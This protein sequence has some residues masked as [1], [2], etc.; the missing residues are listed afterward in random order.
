MKRVLA[1]VL[2]S[3]GAL[4]ACSSGGKP[5]PTPLATK[6][7]GAEGG[8]LQATGGGA[9]V[10]I[11]AGAL[12][13]PVKVTLEPAPTAPDGVVGAAWQLGPEGT[14]FAAPVKLELDVDMGAMP[15]GVDPSWLTVARLE[16]GAWNPLV[17]SFVPSGS[18]K[19]V[20]LT[21]H[22]SVYAVVYKRCVHDAECAAPAQC[23]NQQTC[24]VPCRDAT[25][26]PAPMACLGGRCALQQCNGDA[27]CP[28]PN[29]C[30][31]F[32]EGVGFCMDPCADATT[33]GGDQS[34]AAPPQGGASVCQFDAC[35]TC[36]AG[37]VCSGDVCWP[38]TA[39]CKCG[40]P[41]CLC[42]AP[43][44]DAGAAVD[45]SPA[46]GAAD[47]GGASDGGPMGTPSC[48][49]PTPPKPLL[50]NPG[51]EGGTFEALV[52]RR[53][54]SAPVVDTVLAASTGGGLWRSV[55]SGAT[56]ARVTGV[57][58]RS[59]GA[60]A[61]DGTTFYAGAGDQNEPGAVYASNDGATWSKV[62]LDGDAVNALVAHKGTLWA[63]TDQGLF[64]SSDQGKTFASRNGLPA[65][66]RILS[67]EA[68]DEFVWAGT[69]AAGAFR[70]PA[71]AGDF[72]PLSTGLPTGAYVR[73]L[74]AVKLNGVTTSILAGID[75]GGPMGRGEVFEQTDGA[76][77]VAAS[78][79]FWDD[80]MAYKRVDEFLQ[81]GDTVYAGCD[82]GAG[83][84]ARPAA[85]GSTWSDMTGAV[86]N[87]NILALAAS[88]DGARLF[89]GNFGEG[90]LTGPAGGTSWSRTNGGLLA[91]RVLALAAGKSG[92]ADALFAGT[93]GD[94]VYRSLDGGNNWARSSNGLP[95][96]FV[97]SLDA[98][99]QDVFAGNY[100]AGL[101]AS[102]DGA[103]TWRLANGSGTSALGN[104]LV[105]ALAHDA[106]GVEY[107]GTQGGGV[108]ESIGTDQWAPVNVGLTDLAVDSLLLAPDGKLYAGTSSGSVWVFAGASWT[109][110][111][112]GLPAQAQIMDLAWTPSGALCAA[113]GPL[114]CMASPSPGGAWLNLGGGRAG[115]RALT[116]ADGLVYMGGYGDV[117]E[118]LD[119]AGKCW[120]PE[121]PQSTPVLRM[122]TTPTSVVIGT[123]NG[124]LVQAR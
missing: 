32:S 39:G 73:A 57:S 28:A 20:A 5:T 118:R 71:A 67:V 47:D 6:V 77:W 17:A 21:R 84:L 113:F 9:T 4:G 100:G 82:W 44:H 10:T 89:L 55:D 24:V 65:G 50:Q 54:S 121:L 75:N 64:A 45:A 8:T 19:A 33:C 94:S 78:Q 122:L 98:V 31:G 107:V 60:L 79:G 109:E 111:G 86:E 81:L 88:S 72:T 2:A 95:A 29:R 62:G 66:A 18:M 1:L 41:G 48:D 27:D 26:C 40:T 119:L 102:N 11:P 43:A 14:I 35:G 56:W 99:G 70:A 104:L 96:G 124:L 83:V 49:D 120:R 123:N 42:G 112:G 59:V 114:V 80:P 52:V 38:A 69:D 87:R 36:G 101:Y 63:A 16:N 115:S 106:G 105:T 58:Q 103:T 37:R 25:D 90:V 13:A 74:K 23:W 7:I 76:T 68:D 22:F 93:E 85:A 110:V 46:D 3:I 92:A 117:L 91:M 53:T 116:V 61:D 15:A 97:W 108:F 34:C 51:L 30:A 12:T